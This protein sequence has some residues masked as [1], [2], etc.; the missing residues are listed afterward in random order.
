MVRSGPDRQRRMGCHSRGV[1]STPT[2]WQRRQVQVHCPW[3]RPAGAGQEKNRQPAVY[4][5]AMVRQGLPCR[6][7]HRQLRK[8]TLRFAHRGRAGEG[9]LWFG[10]ECFPM[11]RSGRRRQE[12]YAMP[13][14]GEHA[15]RVLGTAVSGQH[16]CGQ[17]SPGGR[18]YAVAAEESRAF[19]WQPLDVLGRAA[20]VRHGTQSSVA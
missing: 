19:L 7:V 20:V 5:A 16:R 14:S 18:G 12:W 1:A 15:S 3:V 4:L 17:S 10:Q 9:Q 13:S 6:G 2:P 11:A 8:A